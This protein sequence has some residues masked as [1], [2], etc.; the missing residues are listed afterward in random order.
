MKITLDRQVGSRYFVSA[1]NAAKIIHLKDAAIQYLTYTGKNEA[2]NKLEQDVFAKVNDPLEL[3][4]LR[5]DAIMFYHCYAKS[6][7]LGK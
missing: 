2:G 5:A 6:S 3:A 7:D 4:A 1:S